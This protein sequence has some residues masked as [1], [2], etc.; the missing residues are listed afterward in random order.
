MRS[1]AIASSS[2]SKLRPGATRQI[3]R[4]AARPRIASGA[5]LL[6]D[7]AR[8]ETY[9]MCMKRARLITVPLS[10]FCEKARWAL[11]RAGIEYLEEGHIP[12]FHR[13]AVKRAKSPGTS[14][15]VLV[16]D[17]AS[18]FDSSDILAWTDA[19]VPAEHRLYPKDDGKRNDVLALEDQ[20][21]TELG[22]H[23]R[24]VLYFYLLAQRQVAFGLMDQGTP[25]W[26]RS[27]LRVGSPFLFA[28]M[29]RFM[30]IDAAT[31]KAS[32]DA[33]LC[34]FDAMERRLADGRA[35]LVGDRLTAADITLAALAGPAVRP[36]EH[37]VIFPSLESLPP[38]A[39]Q[40]LDEASTRPLGDYIRRIYREHRHVA[41]HAGAR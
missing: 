1:D 38:A 14:V 34:I 15:P 39:R 37:S 32:H 28:G 29:R 11:D 9:L 10:H 13:F 7:D 20:L 21:D 16:T 12:G 4:G 25:L 30:N 6:L 24:R 35:F 19:K 22:P 26:E 40:L 8:R 36:K 41:A 17:D 2:G 23:I 31:S 3:L 27:A 18:L 5:T 33:M